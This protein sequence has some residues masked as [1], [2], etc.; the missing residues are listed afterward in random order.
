MVGEGSVKESQAW[1]DVAR[2]VAERGESQGLCVETYW[3]RSR[4]D[5][6]TREMESE[7]DARI[8]QHM[9]LDPESRMDDRL[10]WV[11]C[12]VADVRVLAALFLS[13]EAADEGK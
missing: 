8:G 12:G 5:R 3:L 9:A 7:M 2:Q 4:F 1:R 6:I 11:K 10:R 13:Y